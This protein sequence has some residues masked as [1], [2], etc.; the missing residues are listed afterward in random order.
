MFGYKV[1]VEKKQK[2]LIN[3]EFIL[4]YRPVKRYM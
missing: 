3:L 2:P 1:T 4:K